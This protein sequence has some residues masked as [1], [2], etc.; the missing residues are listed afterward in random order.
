MALLMLYTAPSDIVAMLG[1]FTIMGVVL[2]PLLRALARRIESKSQAPAALPAATDARLERMEQA[3]EAVAV[4][5]ERISEAQR[6]T[7][8]LLA[9]RTAPA[10]EVRRP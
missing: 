5:V 7:T 6:F 2:Y 3:I 9:E 1:T 10:S 4:E 8:K